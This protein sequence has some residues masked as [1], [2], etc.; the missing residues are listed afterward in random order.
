M[1]ARAELAMW[2][3]PAATD[4]HKQIEALKGYYSN[5]TEPNNLVRRT[6]VQVYQDGIIPMRTAKVLEDYM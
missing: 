2:A 4:D 6:A 5:P 3:Y 1:T